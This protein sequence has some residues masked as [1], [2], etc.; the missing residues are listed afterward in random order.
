MSFTL[1][2]KNLEIHIDA[3][4]ANYNSSRFD[5]TGKITEVKFQDIS[6]STIENKNFQNQDHLGKGFYNEFGFENPVG[7]E[8]TEV[9]EWF[10]KIGVG[11]IK[12]ERNTYVI[13]Q[14]YKLKPAEFKIVFK[15]NTKIILSC[16]S[17]YV[18]GYSY[19]LTK[20]I[21]IHTSGFTITY[22]LKNTGEKEII[23]DEYVHNFIAING[24]S[25]GSNYSLK[26]PFQ[27]KPPLFIET[28]NPEKKVEINSSEIHFN[29]SPKEQFFFSNLSGYENVDAAWELTNCKSKIR[30]KETG[31]FKTKKV[32]IWGWKHV[33]CPELY[34]KISIKP[35]AFSIWSRKYDICKL[36]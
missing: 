13:N 33:V 10:H 12:K 24:E 17:V 23:T 2:N 25:I 30:I 35:G 7:F 9:G 34:Y 22:N 11:L 26:F 18:N 36:D 21:K 14:N 5:W 6:V 8:E 27:I 19:I 4:L 3:P 20:E 32:N 31:S 29:S 1:K 16:T 28:V 15:S